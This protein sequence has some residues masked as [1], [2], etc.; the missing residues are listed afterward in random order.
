MKFNLFT[1][2]FN[3]CRTA[4]QQGRL[5]QLEIHSISELL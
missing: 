4:H 3:S 2:G 5:A 1:S